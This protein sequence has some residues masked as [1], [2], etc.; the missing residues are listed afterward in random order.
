[1]Q[2][3]PSVLFDNRFCI[4]LSA[5][6]EFDGQDNLTEFIGLA[7]HIS[8]APSIVREILE[9]LDVKNKISIT[10]EAVRVKP[11]M[12]ASHHSDTRSGQ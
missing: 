7:V 9:E 2:R 4:Q 10:K 12:I 3:V 6:L 8:H 11:C 5:V 1:M